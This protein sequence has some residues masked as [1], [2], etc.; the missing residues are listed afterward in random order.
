[1]TILGFNYRVTSNSCDYLERFYYLFMV[2]FPTETYCYIT[3]KTSSNIKINKS[4]ETFF[5]IKV[6]SVSDEQIE[7]IC[8]II[9]KEFSECD[10]TIKYVTI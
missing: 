6:L 3:V 2:F 8:A 10:I 5:V 1:M 7:K 4:N 9:K